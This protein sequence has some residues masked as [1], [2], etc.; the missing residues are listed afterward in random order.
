[1]RLATQFNADASNISLQ[2]ERDF[3]KSQL[4]FLR[5]AR[6]QTRVQKRLGE[7]TFDYLQTATDEEYRRADAIKKA[8]TLYVD[9]LRTSCDVEFD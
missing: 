8:I 6:E 4:S 1:M 7:L 5:K 2:T 3:Y 9:G